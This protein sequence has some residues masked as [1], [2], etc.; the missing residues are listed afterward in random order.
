[1]RIDRFLLAVYAMVLLAACATATPPGST[2][3][4]GEYW[5][6]TRS[7]YNVAIYECISFFL[8]GVELTEGQFG[9]LEFSVPEQHFVPGPEGAVA[10]YDSCAADLPPIYWPT[11]EEDFRRVYSKWIDLYHCMVDAGYEMSEGI[12]SFESFW[13]RITNA[14]AE[15]GVLAGNSPSDL[16]LGGNDARRLAFFECHPDPEEFW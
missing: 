2:W 14:D 11:T 12:P 1:V 3:P 15:G 6:G 9:V 8:D 5:T 7:E 16:V 10:L 13:D 4:E